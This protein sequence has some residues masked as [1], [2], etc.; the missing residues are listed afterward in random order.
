MILP[1]GRKYICTY[2]HRKY[3]E[4][5]ISNLTRATLGNIWR[6]T[7]VLI[8]FLKKPVETSFMTLKKN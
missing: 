4:E 1:K 6:N 8:C 3:M 2:R 5:Y 7:G